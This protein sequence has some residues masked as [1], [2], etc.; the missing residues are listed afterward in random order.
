MLGH[1]ALGIKG[2]LC[3]TCPKSETVGLGRHETV[4]DVYLETCGSTNGG[5][6]G[7]ETG[8]WRNEKMGGVLPSSAFT[9]TNSE[10][11]HSR[12]GSS[13]NVETLRPPGHQQPGTT[14]SSGV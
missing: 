6:E 11:V 2:C 3:S 7:S 1:L 5:G 13:A 12:R 9:T 10:P 4:H 14:L 8:R